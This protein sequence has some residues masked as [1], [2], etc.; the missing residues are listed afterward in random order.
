MNPNQT[1]DRD[2]SAVRQNPQNQPR[3]RQR[4]DKTAGR[5][6]KRDEMND[7]VGTPETNRP[8][9]DA[10]GKSSGQNLEPGRKPRE[11]ESG[12]KEPAYESDVLKPG[13]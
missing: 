11:D 5:P 8:I 1:K 13:R 12:P 7:P 3:D 9:D 2:R 4:D 10:K 6:D